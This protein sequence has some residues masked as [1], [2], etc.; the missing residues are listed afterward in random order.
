[1][2][3][4]YSC[5]DIGTELTSL[6]ELNAS[7]T[8][9]SVSKG[10]SVQVTLSGGK[11]PYIIKKQPN[12]A[13]AAVSLNS[14]VLN[15]FGTDTGS[16]STI[17]ADSKTPIADSLEIYILV[18]GTIHTISFSSQIQPIFNSQCT[19]C[20]GSSGGLTITAG[21]SYNNLVNID[22]QSSCTSLKRVLPNNANNSVLYRKVSGTTCGNR[23][24]GGVPLN[25]G[26]IT[27]IQD[28]INQGANNN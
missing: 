16:T 1:M 25:A 27:L 3:A 7:G 22:A 13:I 24:P 11:Q 8:N 9:V 15:I 12:N 21:V 28:W 4:I 23:M 14:S 20:H 5:Q 26:D 19:S 17:I 18:L 2:I 6:H 10:S